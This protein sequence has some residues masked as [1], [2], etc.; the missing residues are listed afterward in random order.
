VPLAW[1]YRG[2]LGRAKST[3]SREMRRNAL[4][5]GRYSLL[6]AAG[7]YQ[8][9]RR[10]ESILENDQRLR[11]F[12]CDRLAEGWT[13]KKSPA[14]LKA[15]MNAGMRALG[16]EAIYASIYRAAGKGEEL[17]RYLT[18][19]HKRRRARRARVVARYD[20]G[21]SFYP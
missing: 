19:R 13:P 2:T 18:R 11:I 17:W 1:R 6:H 5:S 9:R 10:L 7:A 8:L 12:V 20:Q 16:F 3:I 14:G 4:P 15:A 21:P